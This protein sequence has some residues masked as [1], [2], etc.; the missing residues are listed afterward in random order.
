MVME[1]LFLIATPCIQF[2][3]EG[4]LLAVSTSENGIKVLANAEGVWLLHSIEN[5]AVDTS[6]VDPATIAKLTCLNLEEKM[7]SVEDLA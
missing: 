1:A 5:Q 4:I 7:P 6:R 2:Y 3:K